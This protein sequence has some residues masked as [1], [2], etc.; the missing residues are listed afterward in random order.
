[1]QIVCVA[2]HDFNVP[3]SGGMLPNNKLFS[4]VLGVEL[5]F[6]NKRVLWYICYRNASRVNCFNVVGSEPRSLLSR[7]FLHTAVVSASQLK[8]KIVTGKS[9]VIVDQFARSKCQ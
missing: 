1:M 2:Y 6:K 4:A 5:G 9:V 8:D 7:T 3:G